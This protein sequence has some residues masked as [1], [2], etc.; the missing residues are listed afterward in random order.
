MDV[1]RRVC[2]CRSATLFRPADPKRIQGLWV[3]VD[4]GYPTLQ[5][6]EAHLAR[7]EAIL[8]L[9]EEQRRICAGG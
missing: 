1:I 9:R 8:A 2:T 7:R 4:C 6:L 5:R 3:H